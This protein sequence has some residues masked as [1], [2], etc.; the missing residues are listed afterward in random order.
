MI[1]Q[2]G[3]PHRG[4]GPWAAGGWVGSVV[5]ATIV[6]VFAMPGPPSP[7]TDA[8]IELYAAGLVV[9][10]DGERMPLPPEAT[11]RPAP[12]EAQLAWLAQGSIPGTGTRYEEMARQALLDIDALTL[13]LGHVAHDPTGP[14]RYALL[15]AWQD[16]W[17]Y[18]WPRDASFAAIALARSGHIDQAWGI[19]AHLQDVQ[20]DDGTFQARYLP[21]GSGNTP[22]DRPPQ[23]DGVG[24]LLWAAQQ[25]LAVTPPARHGEIRSHL[26]P[27]ISRAT[28]AALR[29]TSH[30]RRLP[31]VSPDYWEVRE[32]RV[33]L[34]TAAPLLIALESAAELG[35]EHAGSAAARYRELLVAT[36][37][38]QG[39]PRHRGWVGT[40]GATYSDT[41]VGF[42]RPPFVSESL[43][44][45]AEAWYES[46]AA[47][48][49]P[50]SGLAPGGSWRNDG[51]SWTPTT[52]VYALVAACTEDRAEAEGWL[53][54]LSEHRT[55]AGSL[56]EKVLSDGSP[57][58]VAPLAWTSANVLLALDC[59]ED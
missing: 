21:D 50:A 22:D 58:A 19:L 29:L 52:S 9:A 3:R 55:R 36:F 39:Y 18:V 34:G 38:E 17:H 10:E 47:M 16:R 7:V 5:L 28:A 12:T 33:T 15:A 11:T 24:W 2:H 44:G 53:D 30:G 32:Y 27:L 37:G 51:I 26:D 45:A 46:R 31:P 59:L 56:P 20:A 14:R 40:M 57:A 4:V 54:W 1:A 25:T 48:A 43:P 6:L 41:S 42:V 8:F 49:R 13:P 35:Q 23:S